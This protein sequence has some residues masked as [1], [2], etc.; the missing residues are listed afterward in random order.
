MPPDAYVLGNE[1]GEEMTKDVLRNAWN[2]LKALAKQRAEDTDGRRAWIPTGCIWPI[3]G[4]RR[5]AGSTMRTY[6]LHR[7]AI[8]SATRT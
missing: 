2:R 4:T 6:R 8:C 5:Q 1:V 7:S 3:S